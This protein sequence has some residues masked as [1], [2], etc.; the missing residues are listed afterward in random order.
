[1]WARANGCPWDGTT[2]HS[3]ARYGR[4]GIVKC[5]AA[6]GCPWCAR[7]AAAKLDEVAARHNVSRSAAAIAWTLAHPAN[8]IPI[9][10]TQEPDGIAE[11][12]DAFQVCFTRQEWYAVLQASMGERLP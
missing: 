3:A 11:S 12:L 6:D 4:V 7:A 10:G 9:I 1:M 2:C 8:V 5:A